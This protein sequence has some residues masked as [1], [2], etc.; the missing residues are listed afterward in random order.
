MI[1]RFVLVVGFVVAL[2]V[3]GAAQDESKAAARAELNAGVQAFRQAHYEEAINHFEQA[4][5]LEPE[6]TVAHLYLATAY[7]QMFV[8][9]V[10]TP[11]N[12]VWATKALDQYSEILRH[13]PSD[14]DS[15][16]GIAY[17]QLQLNNFDQA[18][19]SYA[20]AIALDPS[21]PELFYAAAV[22]N[23]SIANHD[24][25]AEKAKLDAE[26]EYSLIL[27][28]GCADLRTRSLAVIDSGIAMLTKAISLRKDYADAMTYMN[29]LYRLRADL[30]CGNQK[31]Y[32]ADLKQ[33]DE[34]SDRAAA[35]RKKKADAAA[36]DNQE[37]APDKP[38]L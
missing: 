9:R 13:N 35:A 16:K 11:E 6:F 29:L 15:I 38:R 12:V 8:P 20:K 30:E 21:D 33:S 28:E 2:A 36:K 5:A 32:K 22:V 3:A 4:V 31:G 27:S 10:D 19:E 1:A 7:S 37:Q 24:I 25:T 26:S 23:W 34:W 17:L 18:R 14:L